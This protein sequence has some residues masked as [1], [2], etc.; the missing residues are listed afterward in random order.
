MD[1]EYLIVYTDGKRVY[2]GAKELNDVI[3]KQGKAWSGSYIRASIDTRADVVTVETALIWRVSEG[4]K[5]GKIKCG[6]LRSVNIPA[7]DFE[8]G[9]CRE[10]SR[11][12]LEEILVA[13]GAFSEI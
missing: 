8:A 12:D 13:F 9:K 10:I 6:N 2:S 3:D 5:L 11:E 7:E 4:D 1:N